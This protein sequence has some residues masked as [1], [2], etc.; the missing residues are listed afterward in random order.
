[1]IDYLIGPS[2]FFGGDPTFKA[3]PAWDMAHMFDFEWLNICLIF[4][5]CERMNL[6]AHK[7]GF[8]SFD[9]SLS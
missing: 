1:M 4:K 5:K 8:G 9:F 3:F 6:E 7:P 2:F